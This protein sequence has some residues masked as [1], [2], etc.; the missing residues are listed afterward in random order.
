VNF[1]PQPPSALIPWVILQVIQPRR[2]WFLAVVSAGDGFL[3]LGGHLRNRRGERVKVEV[4]QARPN[5][6]IDFIHPIG[7]EKSH[8]YFFCAADL[9]TVFGHVGFQ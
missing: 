8:Y 2:F 6:T 9:L 5:A 4:W 7:H 1:E 3:Q